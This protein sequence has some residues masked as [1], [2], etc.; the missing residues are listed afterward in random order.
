[1][2]NKDVAVVPYFVYEEE[3]DRAEKDKKRAEDDKKRL[4]GI[5]KMLIWIVVAMFIIAI[6]S[7]MAWLAYEN[8]F[9]KV[10]YTQDG[11]GV[12][13]INAGTQGDVG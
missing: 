3:I 2:E 9:D 4:I 8:S 5:I 13:N 12:N 1:M 7:N 6:G 11:K 10:S